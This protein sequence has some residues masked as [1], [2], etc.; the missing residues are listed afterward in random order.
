M[1]KILEKKETRYVLGVIDGNYCYFLKVN[2]IPVPGQF[3]ARKEYEMVT[4]IEIAT[5]ASKR[6]I[7]KYILQDY[8]AAM[9]DDALEFTI[10]PVEVEFSLIKE[11][12]D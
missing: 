5:K 7:A 8:Q 6:E 1:E 2:H 12:D 4:D 10:L 11:V 9:K 3:V